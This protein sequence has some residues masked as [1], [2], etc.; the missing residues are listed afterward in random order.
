MYKYLLIIIITALFIGCSTPKPDK[1]PLW[2]T[3]PPQDSKFFYATGSGINPLKAKKNAVSNL[4]ASIEHDLNKVFLNKSTKLK[5][6]RNQD[7]KPILK[8][9]EIFS[10]TI[11]MRGLKIK[12]ASVF[13]KDHLILI[14]LP[15]SLVFNYA[16]KLFIKKLA[17][18]K[19]KYESSQDKPAINK[20]VT[21]L[22]ELPNY[23]K[24]IS[25]LQAKKLSLK[26][27]DGDE[28]S[29]YLNKIGDKFYKLK[30]NISFHVL[31]DV[32]SKMYVSSVKDAIIDS[33][34]TL[35][36]QPLS[37]DS[38][39]LFITSK[40]IN[41]KDYTFNKSKTLIKYRTY[42]QDKKEVA[43]RQHTF[44][45]KSRVSHQD[46]KQHSVLHQKNMI[47]RLGIYNFIGLTQ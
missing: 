16:D 44:V 1:V 11:V 10:N 19:T 32:N 4:R 21:F 8:E 2:Y 6:F 3:S 38:L 31:S 14:K 39:K 37:K 43:F 18:F 28:E 23:Y 5:I 47:E 15:R 24:L 20:Y 29:I 42:N 36:S 25:L 35:S 22:K 26:T 7:I 13:K 33:G 34:L 9:N 40:T 45:A 30:Q 17:H 27:Y 46:A 41:S 12:E